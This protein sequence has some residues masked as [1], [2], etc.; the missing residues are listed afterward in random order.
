MY[1]YYTKKSKKKN[2]KPCCLALLPEKLIKVINA[3]KPK[4]ITKYTARVTISVSSA[5]SSSLTK[6][7]RSVAL[8]VSLRAASDILTNLRLHV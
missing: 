2:D 7:A 5:V 8:P 4:S 3:H 6:D 1:A